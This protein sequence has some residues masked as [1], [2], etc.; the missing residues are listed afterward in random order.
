MGGDPG[1]QCIDDPLD[2]LGRRTEEELDSH[3]VES[4]EG[5]G[6][7]AQGPTEPDRADD[8]AESLAETLGID[9]ERIELGLVGLLG[10]V[11]ANPEDADGPAPGPRRRC[12]KRFWSI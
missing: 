11:L 1:S 9:P 7:D 2:L 6:G 8:D 4:A 10:L 12:F 3:D 5:R